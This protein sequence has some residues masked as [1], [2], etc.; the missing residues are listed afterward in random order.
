MD[1]LVERESPTE[2]PLVAGPALA[3]QFF[4]IP[5]AVVA[6]TAGI[7][8]GFR[9]LL[10]DNRTAGDYLTEIRTGGDNRRWPAAY[11]LSR[12]MGSEAVRASDP[13]LVPGLVE[14][15]EASRGGDQMVRRY[16]ALALGR[17]DAPA[18]DI[19]IQPLIVA[20]EDEDVETRINA[21]WALGSLKEESALPHLEALYDSDDA[22]VRKMVVY[23]LGAIPQA[24]D[25]A[26]LVGALTDAVPDVQWNAAVALARHGRN[27]GMAV[28]GRMLDREYL[29]PLVK[30]GEAAARDGDPVADVMITALQG[31]VSAQDMIL[32]PVVEHLSKTDQNLRVRQAAMEALKAFGV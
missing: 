11:E 30:S 2:K 7:Y 6:V 19:V 1:K 15:F 8:V 12:L 13:T 5:L 26:V 4:L 22:G 27:D 29:D 21:V 16:L 24:K 20:L 18:P 32:I 25:S 28:L 9:A 10:A 23:A 3:V 14:A 17:I 31:V